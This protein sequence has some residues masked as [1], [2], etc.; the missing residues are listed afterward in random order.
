MI[1]VPIILII[2]KI[3]KVCEEKFLKLRIDIKEALSKYGNKLV[4]VKSIEDI[5]TIAKNFTEKI[6]PIFFISNTTLEGVEL[7]KKLLFHLPA[8]NNWQALVKNIPQ[9][10]VTEVEIDKSM[11]RVILR[12]VVHKGIIR[13]K[14]RMQVGPD[15]KGKFR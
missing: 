10:H 6:V 12:G 11:N 1:K 2:T 4:I 9:F 5:D 14:E 7:L 8:H 13:V 3:D 15:D